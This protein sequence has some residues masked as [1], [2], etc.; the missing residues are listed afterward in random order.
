MHV[1]AARVD[2]ARSRLRHIVK[3]LFRRHHVILVAQRGALCRRAVVYIVNVELGRD[4]GG[5]GVVHHR[6]HSGELRE[7]RFEP[8]PGGHRGGLPHVKIIHPRRH[9]VDQ[10]THLGEVLVPL[11]E[12]GLRLRVG[13]SERRGVGDDLLCLCL[14]LLD[15]L[16]GDEACGGVGRGLGICREVLLALGRAL[17]DVFVEGL[18][19]TRVRGLGLLLAH[20][21][22]QLAVP[23]FLRL[24]ERRRQ[25]GHHRVHLGEHGTRRGRRRG[26]RRCGRRHGALLGADTPGLASGKRARDGSG[27]GEDAQHFTTPGGSIRPASRPLESSSIRSTLVW[28]SSVCC[29]PMADVNDVRSDLL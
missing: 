26:R 28:V 24:G 15:L 7:H 14:P 5:V 1:L 19:R 8:V 16:S 29:W 2:A 27:G 12:I 21:R 13:Q 9:V 10:A 3:S 17:G 18:F 25:P 11:L 22:F 20:H 23:R 4:H 6:L